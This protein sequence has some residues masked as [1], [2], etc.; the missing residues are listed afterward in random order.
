MNLRRLLVAAPLALLV[1]VLAHLAGFGTSHELGGER[2]LTLL[3]SALAALGG[4][5]GAAAFA[6]AL[7]RPRG[8]ADVARELRGALPGSGEIA[9]FAGVLFGGSLL[10]F[11][12]LEL[13]EGHG[14]L[15]ALWVLPVAALLALGT[16]WTVRVATRWLARAGLAF[17]A[18]AREVQL[19]LAVLFAPIEARYV[20]AVAR[21]R[22]GSRRG[23]APPQQ[24]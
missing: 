4:L 12:S 19:G 7:G 21:S 17:A 18:F 10:A 16:A 22:C 8:L 23:R 1:A 20:R 6:A 14:P 24:A 15:A 9:P 2:G 11:W 5:A 3:C 13:L